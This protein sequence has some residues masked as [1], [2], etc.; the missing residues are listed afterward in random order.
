MVVEKQPPDIFTYLDYRAFLRDYFA[1]GQTRGLSHRGL[2][3][4]AG[5]RSPSFLLTVMDGRKTLAGPTAARVASACRLEGDAAEYFSC[6]VAFNQA[7]HADAKGAAYERLKSFARWREIHALDLARDDYFA[8]WYL[9]AI[10]EL[11]ATDAFVEDP[12]WIAR[13]LRPRIKVSEARRALRALIS[14]GLL[15]HDDDGRLRQ[16]NATVSS[17]LETGS[18]QMARFHRAMME[19]ASDAID[20]VPRELRDLGTLTLCVDD[21]GIAELKRRMQTFRRELLLD[22]AS[23]AG[24]RDRVV[25]IN[26]HLFPL[27]AAVGDEPEEDR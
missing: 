1:F 9:P 14:L 23:F 22:E 2:A 12:R 5:I 26:L 25:Q 17:G 15:S 10:R 18:V 4:R 8:Q 7:N 3:R 21:E 11:A 27:T 13:Q 16:T 19:R 24:R 6:L 20:S